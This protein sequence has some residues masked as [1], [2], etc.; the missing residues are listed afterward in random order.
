MLL[1]AAASMAVRA[2]PTRAFVHSRH[3][4]LRQS[5]ISMSASQ[6]GIITSDKLRLLLD[7]PGDVR[8][9]EVGGQPPDR[10]S[11]TAGH[12]PGSAYIDIGSFADPSSPVPMSRPSCGATFAKV[13]GELGLTDSSD[14]VV[15]YARPPKD[16]NAHAGLG[17]MWAARA[18][19]TLWSWGFDDVKLLDGCFDSEA[20]RAAGHSLTS[21]DEQYA[22]QTFCAA[23][24]VDRASSKR[25]TTEEVIAVAAAGGEAQLMDVIPSWPNT[26]QHF[27]RDGHIKGAAGA[28]FFEAVDEKTGR[29]MEREP[30]TGFVE[31]NFD[32]SRPII[33]Y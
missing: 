28:S 33:A 12:I 29:F 22:P 9:F 10:D 5:S 6:G 26:G 24:L 3:L 1:V 25:A 27:G 8:L 11:Y 20:W 23:S 13:L 32:L 4:H 17:V 2:R 7:A 14:T 18:W 19:W 21:G 31:T 15:L 16:A 30:F